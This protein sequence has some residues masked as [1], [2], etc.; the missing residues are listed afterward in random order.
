MRRAAVLVVAV[1]LVASSVPGA[2]ADEY[3]PTKAVHRTSLGWACWPR[4]TAGDFN[5]DG[6]LDHAVVWDRARPRGRCDE[7]HPDARWRVALLLGS[8]LRVE[9]SLSCKQGPGFC[10]PAAGD[11]DGDGRAELFVD[12][13]CGA[14]IAEWHVYQLV[15]A[16][17]VRPTLLAPVAAGLRAGPLV[18]PEVSDSGTHDGFGCRAHPDGTRVLTVWTGRLGR[19]GHWRFERARLRSAG[20]VFRVIGIRRFR[21]RLEGGRWPRG[22]RTAACVVPA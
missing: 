11:L 22:P 7:F 13:C 6:R 1:A 12:A 8:G 3:V 15:G 14:I 20:G 18:L 19:P 2:V 21:R 9:R 5:G 10:N 4:R 16:H 17:L